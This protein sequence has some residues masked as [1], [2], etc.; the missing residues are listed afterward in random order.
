MDS[1]AK[2]ACSTQAETNQR[3]AHCTQCCMYMYSASYHSALAQVLL[4]A[5]IIAPVK[6]H[7][8]LEKVLLIPV[9]V[10]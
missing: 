7:A 1:E 2:K 5:Y 10:C 9:T 6:I 8:E 4:P 3:H